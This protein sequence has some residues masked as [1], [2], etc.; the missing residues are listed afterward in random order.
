MLCHLVILPNETFSPTNNLIIFRQVTV[1]LKAALETSCWNIITHIAIWGSIGIWFVYL[2][3]YSRFWPHLP[4]GAVMADLD[5][6]IFSTWL[7]WLGMAIIPFVALL[8]DIVVK[9]ITRTCF[10]SLADKIIELEL[11]REIENQNQKPNGSL[12]ER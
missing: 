4:F 12:H 10:K 2:L 7:F 9:L 11:A 5:I 8:V 3:I 6:A 1:T